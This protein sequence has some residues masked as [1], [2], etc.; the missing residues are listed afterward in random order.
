MQL[1]KE[2]YQLSLTEVGEDDSISLNNKLYI[3]IYQYESG[4]FEAAFNTFKENKDQWEKL[5][6]LT[7]PEHADN[8]IR[9]AS[10]ENDLGNYNASEKLYKEALN[11]IKD[12]KYEVDF[13]TASCANNLAFLYHDLGQYEEAQRYYSESG[14]GYIRAN[15]KKTEEYA[16]VLNNLSLLYQDMGLFQKAE[17]YK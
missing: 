16:N 7:H 12:S 2:T 6:G 15:S 4:A 1:A 8:L 11:N 17:N 13:I 10:I 9:M 14:N 3:G 5:K